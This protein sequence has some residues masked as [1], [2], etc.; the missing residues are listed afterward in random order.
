MY[1]PSNMSSIDP[2]VQ[3]MA[4]MSGLEVAPFNVDPTKMP[5]GAIIACDSVDQIINFLWDNQNVTQA[6][7]WIIYNI[8]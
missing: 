6:G 3:K 8:L 7:E 4:S 5:S 2:V 1:A